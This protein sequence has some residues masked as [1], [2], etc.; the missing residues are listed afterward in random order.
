MDLCRVISLPMHRK[1]R[2]WVSHVTC[3]V[4]LCSAPALLGVDISPRVWQA[5]ILAMFSNCESE[6]YV[7]TDGQS[8]SLSWNKSPIWGLWPHIYYSQTAA[9]CWYGALTLTR[10]RVCN[11]QLLLALASAVILASESRG[12]RDHILLSQIRDFHFYRLLQLA[13]LRWRYSTPPPHRI[14][15]VSDFCLFT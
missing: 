11:L 8:A 3:C 7:T 4:P 2:L 1:P 15:P 13:E 14:G 6:S 9:V 10:G 5:T 12:T